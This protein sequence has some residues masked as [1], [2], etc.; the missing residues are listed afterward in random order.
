MTITFHYHKRLHRFS[1]KQCSRFIFRAC[2]S[3]KKAFTVLIMR[4]AYYQTWYQVTPCKY[5]A[6]DSCVS[7]LP[8]TVTL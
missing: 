1:S 4:F 3:Y 5:A 2:L 8:L 7:K 6:A